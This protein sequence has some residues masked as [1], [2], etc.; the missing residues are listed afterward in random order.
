MAIQTLNTIKTWFKTGLKPSQTQFWDT[1]D[2]FRH[3]YEKIPLKD[4]EELETALGAKAEKSQL[5]EHTTN[6]YAHA[7]LFLEKEDIVNKGIANGYLPLDEFYKIT[8]QYMNI[9]NDL[10]TGGE[11]TLLSAQ[12]GVA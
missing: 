4:I 8:S 9:V 7:E 10:I 1:W 11:S 6:E 2:S 3:K 5:N 12:Q